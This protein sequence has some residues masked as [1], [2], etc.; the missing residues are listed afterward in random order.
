MDDHAAQRPI[1]GVQETAGRTRVLL[2][3]S[4]NLGRE[5]VIA[6]RR[7]GAEVIAVD[8][9]ADG[10][11]H[12][13]ADQAVVAD[14]TDTGELSA[15]ARTLRPRFVV[16]ASDVVATGVLPQATEVVPG[17]RAAR[18]TADFE[19]MRRLAA[20]ELGLPT[21][22]FWFAGSIAELRSVC[23]HSG[24]PL[25][26]TPVAAPPG[27]GRSVLVRAADIEPAWQYALSATNP[28]SPAR[29]LAE[30]VVEVDHEVT[31]LTVRSSDSAG[32]VVHFCEPIGHR[33]VAGPHG[34]LV[35]EY[36]QPQPMSTI[37]ADAARSIAARVGR[38]LGGR[39][40]FGV[41]L[42]VRGD[43][44]YFAGVTARPYDTALLTLRTQRLS[45]FELQ[46]RAILGLPIDTIMISP[47]AARLTHSEGLV[48]D[49]DAVTRP[50]TV[51]VL[52]DAGTVLPDALA[53]PE[54]DVVVFGRDHGHPRRRLGLAVA[55]ASDVATARDRAEQVS[56][57]LG[58]L[59][60]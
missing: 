12:G 54:S 51:A 60:S 19:A 43:E 59:W 6:L 41:E 9:H 1:E 27:E 58:K 39:G 29:V 23:E 52:P 36:W 15:L 10:P 53:V 13:V 3:G 31:L 20:D 34:Q 11:L 18:L 44:V 14:L 25:V 38:A 33:A 4:R 28:T 30:A 37:A 49:A 8:R 35:A 56:D 26:V 21:V 48:A 40:L 32:P 45:G 24:F 22:P 50:E 46:A 16:T 2:L 47:G 42:L 5:L 57:A 17:L 55:T 7:L